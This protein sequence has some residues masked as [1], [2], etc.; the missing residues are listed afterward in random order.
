METAAPTFT[1]SPEDLRV[2]ADTESRNAVLRQWMGKRHSYHPRE[3][4]DYVRP[5]SNQLLSHWERVRFV[6]APP[7]K[8]TAYLS[9]DKKHITTWTGEP[10]G[11]VLNITSRSVRGNF[12]SSERGTFRAIGINGK[13]YVGKHHGVGMYCTLESA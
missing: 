4:P 8:Y 6:T 3:L 11:T 5:P 7:E 1:P 13:R 10:L 9:S 2:A 12:M